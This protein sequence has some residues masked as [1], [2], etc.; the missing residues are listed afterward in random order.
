MIVAYNQ[1]RDVQKRKRKVKDLRTAAFISSL[2]KISNDYMAL[3]VF[4]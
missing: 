1:I 3:G 2:E 4:P